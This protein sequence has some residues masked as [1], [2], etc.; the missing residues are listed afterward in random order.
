MLLV[1]SCAGS[2]VT[3]DHEKPA[4]NTK[5]INLKILTGGANKITADPN[6]I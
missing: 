6:A 2:C 3:G 5:T 1:L 4:V